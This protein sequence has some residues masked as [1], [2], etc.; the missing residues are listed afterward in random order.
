MLSSCFIVFNNHVTARVRKYRQFEPPTA[1]WSGIARVRLSAN[2]ILV[3]EFSCVRRHLRRT[4]ANSLPLAPH[5]QTTNRSG[6]AKFKSLVS[7]I[8][9][10]TFLPRLL[11]IGTSARSLAGKGHS[12]ILV[13]DKKWD[14]VVTLAKQTANTVHRKQTIKTAVGRV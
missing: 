3:P 1:T 7:H 8:E 5:I 14:G 12:N 9:S 4:S 11:R 13:L 6:H 10:F 2:F